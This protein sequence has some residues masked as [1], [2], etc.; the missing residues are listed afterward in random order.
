M[1]AAAARLEVVAGKA[2]GMS[3]L[4]AD[5]LII[6]RH[7]AGAGQ[8]AQDEE[9]SRAHARVAWDA[10]GACTIEDLGSTNGTFVNGLRVSM[11]QTLVEGDTIEI[12]ATRLLVADLPQPDP[13]AQTPVAS[14]VPPAP[15]PPLEPAL[16][17]AVVQPPPESP[18][19]NG[20]GEDTT[21][22]PAPPTL[23]FQVQIDFAA[24]EARLLLDDA[25]EAVRLVFDAGVWRSE[26]APDERRPA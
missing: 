22:S 6:G 14:P 19:R 15:S 17:A 21:P 25:S 7:A 2:A 23:S 16:V 20:V 18:E 4:V 5:E 13:A 9:I 1:G 24:R 12:G 10:R 8:L 3:I 26:H 11:P